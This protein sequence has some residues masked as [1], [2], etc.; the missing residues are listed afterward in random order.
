MALGFKVKAD[1]SKVQRSL[2]RL[3]GFFDD[4]RR[5]LQNAAKELTRRVW[6]RFAFK[7]DPDGKRWQP[8][9]QSTRLAAK[10]DPK[11]KLMLWS[12]RLRDQTR[13]IAGKK[14][15]RA[16]I[17]APYGIYHEQPTASR[18]AGKLP[19]RAF[20]FSTKNGRR[21]LSESDE[22]YLL[23]ALNYQIRKA[24]Q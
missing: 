24:Q 3:R 23:N 9:A 2:T 5:P 17:G 19:R 13:F 12:R 18:G 10:R 16:V 8:W 6:Y 4:M 22:R 1:D 21:A 20:L 7:R 11:R 15:L 14:D